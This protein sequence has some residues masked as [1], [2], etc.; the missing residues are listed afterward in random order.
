MLDTLKGVQDRISKAS[1]TSTGAA[2]QFDVRLNDCGNQK[3]NVIKVVC[4][5]T[6]MKLKKAWGLACLSLRFPYRLLA[7]LLF[8][9]RRGFSGKR[10]RWTTR[11][12]TLHHIRLSIVSG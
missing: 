11:T 4:K 7:V 6:G 9:L 1:Q 10:K 8:P 3:I 5:L 2:G 12:K